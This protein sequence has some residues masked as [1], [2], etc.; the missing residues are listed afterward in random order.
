MKYI[1]LIVLFGFT[2]W[3]ACMNWGNNNMIES[4]LATVVKFKSA[5]SALNEEEMKQYIRISEVFNDENITSEE[6][7]DNYLN[8]LK[9]FKKDK[10]FT[11][12][13]FYYKYDIKE[14]I[15]GQKAKIVFLQNETKQKHIFTLKLIKN[16][17]IIV[18]IQHNVLHDSAN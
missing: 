1:L 4:P 10:K 3:I 7:F 6:A 17:W 9:S 18:K 13:F 14:E 12:E 2:L 8:F 11:T 16:K 15:K 5:E